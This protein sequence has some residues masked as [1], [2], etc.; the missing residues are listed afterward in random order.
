MFESEALWSLSFCPVLLMISYIV[1][2]R[3]YI[4]ILTVLSVFMNEYNLHIL[5]DKILS[6]EYF[7]QSLY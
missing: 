2:A 3:K 7:V 5:N 4:V 6:L 1:T